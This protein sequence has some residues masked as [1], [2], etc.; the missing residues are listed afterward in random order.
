MVKFEGYLHQIEIGGVAGGLRSWITDISLDVQLF[1]NVHSIVGS[2]TQARTGS[3]HQFHCIQRQWSRF[4]LFLFTN[5]FDTKNIFT[6]KGLKNMI[7]TL[8]SKRN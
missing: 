2:E 7:F 4:H 3:S 6:K 1:G 8:S 5:T